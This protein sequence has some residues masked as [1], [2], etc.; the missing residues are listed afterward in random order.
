MTKKIKLI[1]PHEQSEWPVVG[2]DPKTGHILLREGFIEAVED[3]SHLARG[4]LTEDAVSD[5][6]VR[7]YFLRRRAGFPPCAITEELIIEEMGGPIDVEVERPS[8]AKQ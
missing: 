4:A 6:L 5:L 8:E 2:R 3:A 1:I 7:W